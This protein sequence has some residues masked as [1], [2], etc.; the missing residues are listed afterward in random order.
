[1]VMM[2][3]VGAWVRGCVNEVYMEVTGCLGWVCLGGGG[4]MLGVWVGR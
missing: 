2:G 3:C 4:C 1:M